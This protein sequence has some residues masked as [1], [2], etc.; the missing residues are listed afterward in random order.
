VLGINYFGDPH[1]WP[2][3][4][5]PASTAYTRGRGDIFGLH[6]VKELVESIRPE[7]VVIMN[8]PWNL[9]AYL[10]RID[11]RILAVATVAVDGKNVRGE[12]FNG[13]D[14]TIFW[15]NFAAREATLG[16]YSGHHSVVP[17][18]VDLN[19]YQPMEKFEARDALRLPSRLLDKYIVG[20]VNRNQPRKR[21]DMTIDVFATWVRKYKVSDAYLFLHVAPTGDIG[22]DCR[23]LMRYY[24]V[25]D[26][27]ILAEPDVQRGAREQHLVATYNSF[28][29]QISTTLG[30]GW[31]LTTLEGM[32]CGIP[33]VVPKWSALGE[34]AQHAAWMIE[35]PNTFAMPNT[36]NILGGIA[37]KEEM[38]VALNELYDKRHIA[39]E[40]SK[41]GIELANDPKYRWVNIANVYD[42]I[43]EDAGQRKGDEL[44]AKAE[45]EQVK[46][47]DVR[48]TVA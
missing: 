15:T 39:A 4:I 19:I 16:G 47:E 18:G 9:K 1:P 42:T 45:A 7:A 22:Y 34:W 40:L 24:G 37:N 32:A 8:D 28:D 3:P 36:T 17:L 30:E 5:Y 44:R 33:Q 27:L 21:L 41:R 29:A 25:E 14:H 10:D 43:L 11:E 23:Q 12:W 13:L 35:C 38:V 26:R 46:P 2:Y 20:N 6:R 31:G 48:V